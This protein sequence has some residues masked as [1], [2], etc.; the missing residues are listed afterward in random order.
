MNYKKYIVI[1]LDEIED[2]DFL[3][4]VFLLVQHFFLKE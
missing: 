1:M 4:S 3:K 2:T